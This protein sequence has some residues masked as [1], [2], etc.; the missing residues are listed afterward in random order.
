MA[1]IVLEHITKTFGKTVALDDVS[2]EVA[3]GE[4][5]V[6]F[7]PAGAGKTTLLNMIAGIDDPDCGNIFFDESPMNFVEPRNRN[8]SMVFENYALYPQ[9]SV[10]DNIASPLRSKMHKKDEETIRS[11]VERVAKMTGMELYLERKP[12]QLSNGQRQ[13]VALS[14]ALVRNPNV[15][16]LD[17]PI[18]HLD[19]KLRNAMRKELKLMQSALSCTS[20]YVTHDFTEAMSLGDRIAVLNKGKIVQIGTNAEVYYKPVNEFVAKLFGDCEINILPATVCQKDGHMVAVLDC[21][22]AEVEV[23]EDV[24]QALKDGEKVDL[25]CRTPAIHYSRTPANGHISGTVYTVEP[26]GNKTQ[27]V[28]KAGEELIRFIV[29]VNEKFDLDE[30]V[31]LKLNPDFAIFFD[32]ATEEYLACHDIETLLR[33]V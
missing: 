3:N 32:H 8:V 14:R 4:F 29:P 27:L 9:M 25:G 17:E 24:A 13:R 6:L 5:L 2:L 30:N 20:I 12:S 31:Y 10:Y 19:A 1:K 23:P 11:E 26:L 28:V 22:G 33:E 16:L 7:G 18:A 15:F 21:D